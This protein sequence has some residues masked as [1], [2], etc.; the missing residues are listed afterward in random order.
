MS[1]G[2]STMPKASS[3]QAMAAEVTMTG[4]HPASRTRA[5]WSAMRFR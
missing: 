2:R 1:C 4:R 3:P 5:I